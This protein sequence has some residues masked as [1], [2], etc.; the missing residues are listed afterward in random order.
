[1]KRQNIS[2]TYPIA[3]ISKDSS[4]G[5]VSDFIEGNYLRPQLIRLTD[6]E[7]L[8]FYR[9]NEWVNSTVNRIT[10]DCVRISPDIVPKDRARPITGRLRD[11]IFTVRKFIDDP[12]G[13]KESFADIRSKTI[14]DLLIFGRGAQEK[15]KIGNRIKELFSIPGRKVKINA[16]V[17][18]NLAQTK[19]YKLEDE[20]V[21]SKVTNNSNSRTFPT[22]FFDIDEIIFM[23]LEP[24]SDTLYGDKP[25]DTLANT[26]AS[27]ILRATYNTNFF[28]NGAEARGILSLEKMGRTELKKF[29]QMWQASHK[30]V[31]NA[32][33]VTAVNV[34]V[35]YVRMALTNQDMQFDSYG[36]ELRQKIFAVY[37]MQPIIMGIVDDSGTRAQPEAQIQAY[38]DG[39]IRPI[40][41]LESYTYTKEIIQDGFGFNDIEM[42]FGS[43]D[44]LD[45]KAQSDIDR[46]DSQMGIITINEIRLRRGMPSV[47][48]G[49]TP[50]SIVPGG[51]QVDGA[52]RLVPPSGS[53]R[54][55]PNG[56]NGQNP[57]LLKVY[58]D[59][60]DRYFE[61]VKDH[62]LE[63]FDGLYS[64]KFDKF[65]VKNYKKVFKKFKEQCVCEFYLKEIK[66][67][68][69][70]YEFD[71]VDILAY[72]I[73]A[74][75]NK[76]RKSKLYNVLGR[77]N[78][79]KNLI[80]K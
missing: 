13:N 24:R 12:N 64:L 33:R 40:L 62:I 38:K 39:A 43:L 77:K 44:L 36:R 57:K 59:D 2:S 1:M 76:V 74:L 27:D 16:D 56:Q 28:I 23:V 79:K 31:A 4:G 46:Q 63:N 9:H 53:K 11:R 68:I 18:G 65:E 50:V 22:V 61:M 52:G 42:T 47:P 29:R 35:N 41:T 67:L 21:K 3:T 5:F 54:P 17:H 26:V 60:L 7:A 80:S 66:I 25:L 75:I 71:R 45:A 72:S 10:N 20:R 55:L 30:G 58:H 34:P 14:R 70:K 78:V 15:V 48:W 49:D 69:S 51:G 6:D 19:T 8:Q 37:H 73:D 32:H